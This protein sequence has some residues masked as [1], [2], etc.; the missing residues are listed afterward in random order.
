MVITFG[1]CP[2]K[3]LRFV[4]LGIVFGEVHTWQ[5]VLYYEP[6]SSSKFFLRN[7][8]VL[9]SI[10]RPEAHRLPPGIGNGHK[11]I[12]SQGVLELVSDLSSVAKRNL[13]VRD[14][15]LLP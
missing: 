3:I 10:I 1:A 2:G 4:T 12:V 9:A 15:C 5:N 8:A 7:L 6:S 13:V 14:V 11:P